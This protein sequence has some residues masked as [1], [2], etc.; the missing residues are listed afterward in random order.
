MTRT[1]WSVLCAAAM[2]ASAQTLPKVEKVDHQPLA[3]AVKRLDESL[4][5]LGAPLPEG[6]RK[7][8]LAACESTDK[9]KAIAAIQD[10]LDKH[11]LTYVHIN[12][13]SR[14]KVSAGPAAAELVENGWRVFLVKV[15]NEAGVTAELKVESPQ[16]MP[17]WARSKNSP[18]P[19]VS[20][21]PAQAADRFLEA[22]MFN[23]QPMNPRLSGLELEYR[24]IQLYSRDP[25]RREATLKFNVG[26]GT[27]DIGF[28]NDVAILFQCKPATHVVLRVAD[29]DGKPV[30][31]SFLITDSKGRVYPSPTKR[32]APDFGFHPQV[33]RADGEIVSLPPGK[34]NVEWSRGPEYLVKR[35]TIEVPDAKSCTETFKLTRWIDPAAKGWISGDHHIHAAGCAHYES[36]A[37]GVLPEHMMRH[38]LGED[39]KVG[40][41]LSWGPCW[42]FQKQFFEGRPHA[43]SQDNYIMRYDVEVSGFPSSH[44][45]HLCL[46]R[47]KHQDFPGTNRIEQW[48]S[49]T[50]PILEWGQKQGGVVGYSHSGWGLDVGATRELPNFLIPPMNGIGAN[51]YIVTVA[52]GACDFISTV[53][54]PSVWEL[55]IW[56][57]TLNAG[58]RC[59]V[60]GE[61]DFPC[62]Y[63]Q[64]VGLGRSYVKLPIG[65]KVDFDTWCQ[66]IKDGRCYVSDGKTH[67]ID[68]AVDGVE[69]GTQG[70][71]VK[72]AKPGTVKITAKVAALLE[73]AP[74]PET[75][76]V[77]SAP[78]P[79]KPYWDIERCRI[80]N[81][82]SVP[83]E[84]IVNGYPVAR[85]EIAA[86]GSVTDLNLDI[87]ISQS[88]WVAVRVLP[89]GHTNPMFVTVDGKPIRASRKSIQW[90]IDALDQCWKSKAPRIAAAEREAARAAYDKARETYRKHLAEAVSD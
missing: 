77:R 13:E 54:T 80:G 71:E 75:E 46:L 7:A 38:I 57:H 31:A 53:D 59:R 76:K 86:D 26:Q 51:E 89:A 43:L 30:M 45:G 5:Y 37:E 44:S 24:I 4:T 68:F 49:W 62:I 25:G 20:I 32:L 8:L 27:Q 64:K 70:S 1:L 34:Y 78:L 17:V 19:K 12:P 61:T 42:Y 74:T 84:V 83:V 21:T 66:G 6:D 48:P 9:A 3:S 72:L 16:S 87:P 40:C 33:Y 22:V 36:P 23:S 15:A 28:R 63:G 50:Q 56:Y 55:N 85:R 58:F 81:T 65:A 69:M 35:R 29:Q 14:V 90:C 82:R 52:N 39:L 88:S 47:L 73:P 60:S 41:V 18:E 11:C 10:V 79:A 67:I 2:S